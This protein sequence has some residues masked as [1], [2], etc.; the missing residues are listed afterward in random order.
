MFNVHGNSAA[1][2]ERAIESWGRLADEE[3]A[4][5]SWDKYSIK[6]QCEYRARVYRRTV[7]SLRIE[8]ATGVAHC[9]CCLKPLGEDKPYWMRGK[10]ND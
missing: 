2:L 3:A 7:E 1:D 6:E 10:G 9:S 5:P 8:L 4:R